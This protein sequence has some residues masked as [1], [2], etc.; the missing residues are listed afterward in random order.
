MILGFFGLSMAVGLTATVT[1]LRSRTIPNWLSAS[2][3]LIGLAAHS[4]LDGWSGAA[5]A[6][7]G[8]LI[9]FA[10]FLIFYLLGGMGGGDVKLMAAFGAILGRE[11]ILTA[12]IMTAFA[13]GL[14]ALA[15]LAFKKLRRAM[16]QERRAEDELDRK[17]SMPYAPAILMGVLLS[18][19]S[20]EELW[21]NVC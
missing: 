9:G 4:Y 3:L 1:D 16:R 2:A 19:L 10:V 13:G 6:S 21:T 15:Y 11:Q 17:D 20:E 7:L 18:F 14:M 12:A 5:D 8:V